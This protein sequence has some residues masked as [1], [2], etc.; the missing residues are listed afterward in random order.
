MRFNDHE[1]RL[2]RCSLTDSKYLRQLIVMLASISKQVV[3]RDD[4]TLLT[5]ILTI[6]NILLYISR[7]KHWIKPK[8]TSHKAK[9]WG[10][11]HV[12]YEVHM[13]PC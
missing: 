4:V 5:R 2:K 12:K 3:N 9:G 13:F 10:M 1:S 7:S 6:T 11:N 8:F